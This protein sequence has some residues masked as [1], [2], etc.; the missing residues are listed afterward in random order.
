MILI[1]H[2]GN[3]NGR[4]PKRENR[5]D[6]IWEALYQ[7]YQVEVDVW[8]DKGWWLGHNEP[9]YK[10]VRN[11]LLHCWCHA[12]NIEALSRM[13]LDWWEVETKWKF[14][15]FWHQKDDYTLTSNGFIWVYPNKPL[16]EGCICVL[17]EKYE[18]LIELKVLKK[19]AG[20]CSDYISYYKT[21]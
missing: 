5:P 3:I 9:Q 16:I 10:C 15:S 18:L 17:P 7:R 11:D 13:R 19:C 6:Y 4:N 8:Y 20:I 1:S 21:L 14:N 12:K 2:R